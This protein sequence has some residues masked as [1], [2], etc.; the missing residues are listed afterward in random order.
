MK[1]EFGILSEVVFAKHL[2][3]SKKETEHCPEA[4]RYF[5]G[6]QAHVHSICPL[7][8][9]Q[10]PHPTP[11]RGPRCPHRIV[12]RTPQTPRRGPRQTP[13]QCGSARRQRRTRPGRQAAAAC[14]LALQ[15]PPLSCRTQQMLL[16]PGRRQH[17][18]TNRKRRTCGRTRPRSR[19][20]GPVCA[21]ARRGRRPCPWS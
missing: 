16:Q 11:I 13:G 14:A 8:P 4:L 10:L 18:C 6:Q 2:F 20:P 17:R 7:Q 3:V 19:G 12:Q 9:S 1:G 5:S 15:S 21:T